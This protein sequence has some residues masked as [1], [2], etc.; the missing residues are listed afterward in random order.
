MF[1]VSIYDLLPEPA[2]LENGDSNL[3]SQI[4]R[5][6]AKSCALS[7]VEDYE[8]QGWK[9]FYYQSGDLCAW[10][11]VKPDSALFKLIEV[12]RA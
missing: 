7:I 1:D 11:L 6:V 12:S 3:G 4:D 5:F 8:S 2:T 10:L 9:S